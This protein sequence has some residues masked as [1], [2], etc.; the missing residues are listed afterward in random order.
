[1][2]TRRSLNSDRSAPRVSLMSA[3][4]RKPYPLMTTVM[5]ARCWILWTRLRHHLLILC[6]Q[7]QLNRMLR[8][9]LLHEVPPKTESLHGDVLKIRRLTPRTLSKLRSGSALG[10]PTRKRKAQPR[11]PKEPRSSRSLA[12]SRSAGG[13]RPRIRMRKFPTFL[14]NLS[15]AFFFY[16]LYIFSFPFPEFTLSRAILQGTLGA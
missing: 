2:I 14:T 5:I 12:T 15:L 1:M 10:P 7:P 16:F 3:L 6:P 8:V 4:P 9:A 11:Q 13:D